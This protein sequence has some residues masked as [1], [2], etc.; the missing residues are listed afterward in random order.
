MPSSPISY[1]EYAYI[2]KQDCFFQ[3]PGQNLSN[4]ADVRLIFKNNLA[5]VAGSVLYGGAVDNCRLIGVDSHSSGEVFDML[6]RI[7]D[8]NTNSTISS[9][10]LHICPCEHGLS[11]C[12]K[13][14][15][16][17]PFMIHPGETFQV[18]VVAV[19][20]RNGVLPST[21]RSTVINTLQTQM[22]F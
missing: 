18:S 4:G 13:S 2:P 11:D 12:S 5:D 7:G 1:C 6:V 14:E 16:Y 9:N 20:Q 17:V 3:L 19:G 10:P 15:Y 22:N 21:V 8:D